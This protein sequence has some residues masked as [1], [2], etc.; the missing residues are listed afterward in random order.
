MHP[1]YRSIARFRQNNTEAM[2]K[3]LQATLEMYV[4]AGCEISGV[5]FT[6]GT[7]L[8]ANASDNNVASEKRIKRLDSAPTAGR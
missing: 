7:K 1:D 4:E 3:L 6:D 2:N 8:Y 5:V